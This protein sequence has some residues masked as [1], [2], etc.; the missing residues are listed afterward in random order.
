MKKERLHGEINNK[1]YVRNTNESNT[2]LLETYE[3]DKEPA[4]FNNKE[5]VL[6]Y[7]KEFGIKE[8]DLEEYG[9]SIETSAIS[10]FNNGGILITF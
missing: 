9:I 10:F 2:I 5:D 1:Y 4:L 7:L 3:D 6:K 8:N